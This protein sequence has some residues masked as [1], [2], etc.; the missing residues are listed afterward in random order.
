MAA[1]TSNQV[2][3]DQA[4]ETM[5]TFV[6]VGVTTIDCKMGAATRTASPRLVTVYDTKGNIVGMIQVPVAPPAPVMPDI[7]RGEAAWQ[8]VHEKLGASIIREPEERSADSGSKYDSHPE[9]QQ[10]EDWASDDNLKEE[11]LIPNPSLHSLEFKAMLKSTL[12]SKNIEKAGSIQT[13]PWYMTRA[14]TWCLEESNILCA[15]SA[16]VPIRVNVHQTM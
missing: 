6:S 9:V 12:P 15:G 7:P 10:S 2:Q 13:E 16:P 5:A 3:A 14:D 4:G 8:A 1:K 11:D